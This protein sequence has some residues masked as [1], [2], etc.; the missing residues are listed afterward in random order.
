MLI[1]FLSIIANN[2]HNFDYDFI[3]PSNFTYDIFGKV[4]Y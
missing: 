2:S 1:S 3:K 4:K